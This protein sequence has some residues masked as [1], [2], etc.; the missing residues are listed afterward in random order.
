MK[1]KTKKRIGIVAMSL[2]LVVGIAATAGTTLAKYISS[3]TVDSQKATVAQWGYTV[4]TDADKLFSQTYNNGKI[5]S[6]TEDNGLDVKASA[7]YNVVAPGTSSE[8]ADKD[9][10]LKFTINGSAEVDAHLVIDISEFKT[11][12]LNSAAN[13]VITGKDAEGKDTYGNLGTDKYYPLQWTI[14]ATNAKYAANGDTNK[15]YSKNIDFTGADTSKLNEKLAD[16]VKAALGDNNNY[17]LPEKA[18]VNATESTGSQVVIELPQGTKFE[19]FQLSI[20][21]KWEFQ[22]EKTKAEGSVGEAGY[23]PATYYDVEDTVL[24]WLAYNKKATTAIEKGTSF[25]GAKEVKV[26]LT[27]Y[28]ATDYNL[29]VA[30]GLNVQIV[31]VQTTH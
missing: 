19:N 4:S 23:K 15:T 9:G 16:A 25:D 30:I 18:T 12:W 5:V 26:D 2:A 17:I 14:S 10:T 20:S 27:K 6:A 21:W 8:M 1:N 29:D 24:G 31:Q 3:A 13:S 11:V 28:A 7:D 22:K